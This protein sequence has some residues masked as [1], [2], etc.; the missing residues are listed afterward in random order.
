MRAVHPE[1]PTR[2]RTKKAPTWHVH[3]PRAHVLCVTAPSPQQS[4]SSILRIP[5][6]RCPSAMPKSAAKPPR[7]P[8][9]R[10]AEPPAIAEGDVLYL[11][12][13]ATGAI[14]SCFAQWP[15]SDVLDFQSRH[16]ELTQQRAKQGLVCEH[17]L[18][19]HVLEL[20][21]PLQPAASRRTAQ[22]QRK[23][24]QEIDLIVAEAE[25]FWA[26]AGVVR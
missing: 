22:S 7:K 5:R 23:I 1:S 25:A 11:P 24:L 20:P 6:A 14:S 15:L 18:V 13:P 21:S 3:V 26:A 10:Y 2:S 8:S 9:L 4:L 16:A 17:R 12:P 19:E